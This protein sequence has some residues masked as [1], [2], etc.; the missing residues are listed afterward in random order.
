MSGASAILMKCCCGAPTEPLNSCGETPWIGCE[1]CSC[2]YSD[3][4][5]VC[6][7][8]GDAPCDVVNNNS[9]GWTL[10][11]DSAG[12]YSYTNAG[13]VKITLSLSG[14]DCV[15]FTL[16]AYRW[17][18]SWIECF[19]TGA[20]SLDHSSPTATCSTSN[21]SGNYAF[22]IMPL[23]KWT[24]GE[25]VV[26]LANITGTGDCR[27][28]WIGQNWQQRL[29][30]PAT[31]NG[32][33]TLS[34]RSTGNVCWWEGHFYRVHEY[35]HWNDY[36]TCNGTPNSEHSWYAAIRLT[37]YLI[38][39][40]LTAGGWTVT[41]TFGTGPDMVPA[42][43]AD[44]EAGDCLNGTTDPAASTLLE[45]NVTHFWGGTATVTPTWP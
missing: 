17:D 5:L 29:G 43:V 35:V 6:I 40:Q 45:E 34:R 33:F 13:V 31:V 4:Y 14:T 25:V 1:N 27:D 42:F 2:C 38:L 24:P 15:T 18:G 3:E 23:E 26:T 30:A 12:E 10:T 39:A 8:N 19:N 41:A 21:T 37:D 20:S 11:E 22:E 16:I 36:D 32:A 44:Q 7:S 28:V 9:P